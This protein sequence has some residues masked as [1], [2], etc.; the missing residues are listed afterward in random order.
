MTF[1]Q[2]LE[3]FS[4]RNKIMLFL[5]KKRFLNP[6]IPVQLHEVEFS[7]LLDNKNLLKVLDEHLPQY[8]NELP[9]GMYFPFP[10]SSTLSEGGVFS[11][12]LALRFFYDFIHVDESQKWS[13]RGKLITGK[14]LSL[15]ESNLFFED[16]TSRCFVEYWSENRWDKCYLKCAITPFLASSIENTPDGF[17]LLLNNH[18]KDLFDLQSL[19]IDD[20]ERCFVR[21][22][23][24]G[25][26][27]LADAP[28][29]WLLDNLNESGSHLVV[30]EHLFP[31]GVSP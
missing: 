30:D 14:V 2:R 25:E 16:E 18:K 11:P 21:S 7:G 6:L 24:H 8:E 28:R 12:E 20:R 23:N 4:E 26:V 1:E 17:Q 27:L 29:F 31:L 19:R 9:T 22:Q 3:W 10:M 5:W 13:L 15:F